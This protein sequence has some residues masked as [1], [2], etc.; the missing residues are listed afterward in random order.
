MAWENLEWDDA[1]GLVIALLAAVL[2][3]IAMR[4][5]ARRPT[6]RVLF[7]AAAF[8]AFFAKGIVK[9]VEIVWV[10]ES[11]VVDALELLLDAL[12]LLLFFLGMIKG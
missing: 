4:A 1:V 9:V 7:F 12:V 2:F 8:G 10:G 5:Y 6:T 3:A 11:A